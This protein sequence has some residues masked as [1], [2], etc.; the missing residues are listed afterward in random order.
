MVEK[1]TDKN[2]KT[3]TKLVSCEGIQKSRIDLKHKN[4]ENYK[5]VKSVWTA[6]EREAAPQCGQE[7]AIILLDRM[8]QERHRFGQTEVPQ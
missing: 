2:S 8:W 6:K 7:A 3:P 4:F 5:N 1:N